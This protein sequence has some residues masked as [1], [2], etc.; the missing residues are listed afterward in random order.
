MCLALLY[1]EVKTVKCNFNWICCHCT[2]QWFVNVFVE[3]S[4]AGAVVDEAAE[5]NAE[6]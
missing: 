3:A 6:Y 2:F 4:Q 5:F 1:Q